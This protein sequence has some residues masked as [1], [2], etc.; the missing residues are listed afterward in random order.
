MANEWLND[1]VL[2]V[3]KT[4]HEVDKHCTSKIKQLRC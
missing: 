1:A 2:F 4:L 3:Q